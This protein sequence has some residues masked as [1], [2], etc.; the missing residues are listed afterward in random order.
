VGLED[1]IF[2]R[3]G[4]LAKT[5]AELVQ[6]AARLIDDLGGEL[7]TPAETKQILGI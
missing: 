3:H 6:K 5:N 1:N 2:I 4:E 7:A